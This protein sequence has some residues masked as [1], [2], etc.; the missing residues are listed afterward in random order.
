LGVDHF[1]IAADQLPGTV[2]GQTAREL[3]RYWPDVE[4]R[5]FA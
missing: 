5:L 3:Y 2:L 4:D 1:V